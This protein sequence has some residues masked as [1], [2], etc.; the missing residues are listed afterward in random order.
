MLV[1]KGHRI[2][3]LVVLCAGLALSA[4]ST[5]KMPNIDFMRLPEFREAAAKLVEGFPDVGLAPTR[6][7]DIRSAAEWD[8][9]ARDLIQKR[10]ALSI[11][12]DGSSAMT[13][14]EVD[15]EVERLKAQ[16]RRYKLD[17]PQ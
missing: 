4:C 6:P 1:L 15:A 3:T 17:D 9:A 16:I 13:E 10:A 12:K 11:P 8:A 2:K 7:E 5:V 14:A